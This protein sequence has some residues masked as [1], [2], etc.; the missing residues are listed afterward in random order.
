MNNNG[1]KNAP[2]SVETT[3]N[4]ILEDGCLTRRE[5]FELITLFLSELSVTE[6]ER[7]YINQLLDELQLGHLNFV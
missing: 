7:F 3:V 6:K 4:Q 1:Q 2:V 5:Y